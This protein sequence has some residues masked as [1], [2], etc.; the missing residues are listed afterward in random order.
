[1]KSHT[2]LHVLKKTSEESQNLQIHSPQKK[3]ELFAQKFV[4]YHSKID[5]VMATEDNIR[6]LYNDTTALRKLKKMVSLYES[7]EI[8][9]KHKG[10]NTATIETLTPQEETI[11][12]LI[13]EGLQTKEIATSLFISEHTVQTH[14]KNIYKKLNVTSITDLVK[15]SILFAI[16]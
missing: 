11:I 6:Y 9:L 4:A 15:I 14:R 5:T 3:I 2:S 10:I 16:K 7:I 12:F 1:M 8:D 13:A